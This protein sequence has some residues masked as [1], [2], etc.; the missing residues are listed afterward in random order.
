MKIQKGDPTR[1]L[2]AGQSAGGASVHY[3][4]LSPLSKGLFHRAVSFSGSALSP[5]AFM[6]KPKAQAMRLGTILGCPTNSTL[7]LVNCLKSLDA[8]T[9]VNAHT[10]IHVCNYLFT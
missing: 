5:W 9:I 1:V 7:A 3:H 8:N 2:L 4:L 6:T 10:E